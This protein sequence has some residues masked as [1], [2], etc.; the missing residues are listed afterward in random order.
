MTE[1]RIVSLLPS[2]TE[3]VAALGLGWLA[4]PPHEGPATR[5]EFAAGGARWVATRR[6]PAGCHV[7]W[8]RAPC[9]LFP[10]FS[11]APFSPRISLAAATAR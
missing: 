3:I 10:P 11:D 5:V 9:S 1:Q 7:T 4:A 2:A 8:R 6:V